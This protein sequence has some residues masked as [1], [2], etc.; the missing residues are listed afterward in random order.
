MWCEG[1]NKPGVRVEV[2]MGMCMARVFVRKDES[3][4][5]Y[6]KAAAQ[7]TQQEPIP[8]IVEQRKMDRDERAVYKGL[9]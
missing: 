6:Q 9:K 3:M 2:G 7:A 5:Q 4:S 8:T 1:V